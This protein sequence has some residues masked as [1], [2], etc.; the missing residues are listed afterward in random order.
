MRQRS[1]T[2][3][4]PKILLCGAGMLG[5]SACT[6]LTA[7]ETTIPLNSGIWMLADAHHQLDGAT[8][9][10]DPM[11][12]DVHIATNQV[13]L[14]PRAFPCATRSVTFDAVSL[15]RVGEWLS[16]DGD[17]VGRLGPHTLEV[18][19]PNSA[20]HISWD[21]ERTDAPYRESSPLGEFSAH[22]AWRKD[23]TPVAI[24]R[25]FRGLEDTLF[26]GRMHAARLPDA[27]IEYKFVSSSLS[28]SVEHFNWNTGEFSLRPVRDFDGEDGFG[29]TAVS[30]GRES[31]SASITVKFASAFDPPIASDMYEIVD[32]DIPLFLE[33]HVDQLEHPSYT[34]RVVQPPAHG[35][36]VVYGSQFMYVPEPNYNGPDKFTYRIDI[37]LAKSNEAHIYIGIQ[38][39]NDRPIAK[40]LHFEITSESATPLVLQ[41]IDI[42]STNLL[43]SVFQSPQH[44]QLLTQALHW[45]Y[46]PEPGFLQ[47]TDSFSY[48]VFD[49]H[50]WSLPA[51]VNLT[52]TPGP[53]VSTFLSTDLSSGIVP[54]WRDGSQIYFRATFGEEPSAIGVAGGTTIATQVVQKK[55]FNTFGFENNPGGARRTTF[56]RLGTD[57]YFTTTTNTHGLLFYRVTNFV[58][59]RWG[60]IPA[61]SNEVASEPSIGDAYVDASGAY[62]PV[63]WRMTTGQYICQ[64]RKIA[65]LAPTPEL[66][67]SFAPAN[68]LCPGFWSL[69]GEQFMF[70]GTLLVKFAGMALPP[71]FVQ[72]LGNA[73]PSSWM[74]EAGGKLYFQ[75][76]TKQGTETQIDLWVTDGTSAGTKR[77]KQI[78]SAV[79]NMEIFSPIAF[80]DKLYFAHRK[81]LWSSDGT[82]A[83]T[84]IVTTIP[85]SSVVGDGAIGT[86]SA[87]G[88]RMYFLATST[89]AG[90][91]P[92]VSDGTAAGTMMLR[93]IYAGTTSSATAST[94]P[95]YFHEAQGRV[96]FLAQDDAGEAGIWA[97]DGTVAGTNLL[98][99]RPMSTIVG[100]VDNHVLYH[101][102]SSFYS[103][104]LP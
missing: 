67:W 60:E 73:R 83:V 17:V 78:E 103:M 100:I 7:Q 59:S 84:N 30:N 104:P 69:A 98:V 31:D 76:R 49:G 65:S 40:D 87:I 15:D 61:P 45:V 35:T 52:V 63:S 57:V 75:T 41:A 54:L 46:L 32:E 44:G 95:V 97:T 51:T 90:R 88:G 68:G 16:I 9:S 8:T 91:E 93:D 5:L 79:L 29:F 101:D 20:A 96:L 12:L 33:P 50:V 2:K 82:E 3:N 21:L 10:C 28:Y 18:D 77:V 26:E 80:G 81:S 74:V 36:V 64:I 72:D 13:T 92:W 43:F 58:S 6:D 48:D 99:K 70:V 24:S 4:W 39:V 25:S 23:E 102:D 19:L 22:P 1:H 47:G 85:T 94:N 34:P 53:Y 66:L 86:I 14:G 62:V 56:F 55:E 27:P 38:P 37:G 11:L 71:D 89:S 42:D